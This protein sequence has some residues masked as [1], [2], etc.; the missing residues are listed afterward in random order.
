MIGRYCACQLTYGKRMD[1]ESRD[2]NI[3]KLVE[4]EIQR[5]LNSPTPVRIT[6]SIIKM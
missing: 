2:I 4:E 1:W 5:L 3:A 6:L